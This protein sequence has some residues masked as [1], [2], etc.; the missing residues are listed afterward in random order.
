VDDVEERFKEL[1]LARL[2]VGML[3]TALAE[4]GSSRLRVAHDLQQAATQ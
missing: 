2:E 3:R 1:E 4:D